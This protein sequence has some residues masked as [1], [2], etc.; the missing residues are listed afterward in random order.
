[1][2]DVR[3]FAATET[4]KSGATVRVRAVRPDDKAAVVDAFGKLEPE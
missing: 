2:M 4:L 1:M 3:T